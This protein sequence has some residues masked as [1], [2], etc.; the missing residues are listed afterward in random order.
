MTFAMHETFSKFI[1]DIYKLTQKILTII[2][3]N[4]NNEYAFKL[5]YKIDFYNIIVFCKYKK[6]F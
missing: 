1:N 2:I 4:K 3:L 5:K 6:Y